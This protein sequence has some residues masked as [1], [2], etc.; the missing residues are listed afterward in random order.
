MTVPTTYQRLHLARVHEATAH[1]LLPEFVTATRA[2]LVGLTRSGVLSAAT[3]ARYLDG[4]DTVAA[5][6][7]AAPPPDYDGTF[8]DAYYLLEQLLARALA[9]P[10][11]EIAVQWGRSRNDLDAAVFRRL[12]REDALAIGDALAALQ[13]AVLD[14]AEEH[15]DSLIIGFTHRRP[16]QPTTIGHV[17]AGLAEALAEHARALAGHLDRLDASPLGAVA[18][19]GTDVPLDRE[20]LAEA[21]GFSR[22]LGNSYNAVAGAEVFARHATALAELSTLIGRIARTLLDWLTLGWVH[23]PDEFCQGSSAMPQKRNPVVLEHLASY[24]AATV[25]DAQAVLGSV[26]LSWWEDSNNATTDVQPRLW[27]AGDRVLRSLGLLARFFEVFQAGRLPDGRELV[28]AGITTTAVADALAAEGVPFR[29]AHS[30]VGWL[31]ADRNPGEW[32]SELIARQLT[33][34]SIDGAEALRLARIGLA[35]LDPAAVLRRVQADGPGTQAVAGQVTALRDDVA[36][37]RGRLTAGRER[38]ARGAA[39]LAA[40]EGAIRALRDEER[41]AR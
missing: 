30:I 4:L 35:A 34:H 21:L 2:H 32:T 3:T 5:G 37:L 31:A 40:A 28:A 22:L 41:S 24:T 20:L 7:A 36:V 29:L 33:A 27:E 26:G 39:Q 11:G 13:T 9:V 6:I 23:T 10:S 25:A 8:E 38:T 17:L 15:R 14:R 16:A 12:L 1:R 18:F 19:A